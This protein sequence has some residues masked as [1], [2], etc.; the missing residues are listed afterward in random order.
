[1]SWMN[2]PY[3]GG[4][5]QQQLVQQQPTGFVQRTGFQPQVPYQQPQPTG[6]GPPMGMQPQPTGFAPPQM[7]QPMP[8]G[9]GGMAPPPQMPMNTGFGGGMA[10]PAPLR[11][12][13][14]GFNA[15]G[16]GAGV[17]SQFLST[18]MPAPGSAPIQPQRTGFNQ[19]PP[20]M[21]FQQQQ[22]GGPSLQQQFQ[23]SNQQQ[24]GHAQVA[25]PWA[26]TPEEKKR[27]DQIFRAWD[28]QG[29]G[30]LPGSMAKEVFGQAGLG[31]DDLMAI[32]N[33]ADV[34]DRG[35]LNID[36]FHVAMGLI[37]RRLNGNPIPNT[38]P[39]EMA[40]PS[41][42]DLEDSANFLTSLLKNDTNRR[43]TN[44][45]DFDSPQSRAKLRSLHDQSPAAS[46]KD[47][48][49]F[50]NDDN[51]V[52]AYKSSARHL[53]R[54]DVRSN[55]ASPSSE[56]DDVKRR[57]REAQR[58]V[59]RSREEDDEEEDL[60]EE[61]RRLNRKI[62]RVQDDLD[63]NRRSGRRTAAKDEERRLLERELLRLEHEDLPR[64]EKRLE[65]KEREKRLEQKKYAIERD[66]RNAASQRYAERSYRDDRDYG[67]SSSS[68]YADD[69]GYRS[70]SRRES[71]E[72]GYQ[73]GTY[74]AYDRSKYAPSPPRRS[75]PPRSRTPPPPPPAPEAAKVDAPP[76]PPP[77]APPS[78]AAAPDPKSM[79]PAERQAFIRAE[80]QRRIQDRLRAL[81]V[82]APSAAPVDT[83]VQDR[84]EAEKA[85]AARKAKEAD[86]L[87][88][89][90]ELERQAKLERERGR[91]QQI[92]AALQETQ[93][94]EQVVEQV[95]EEVERAAGLDGQGN[96]PAQAVKAAEEQLDAEEK[97][98]R[99]RE[100]R[101]R[102]EKEER[103]RRIEEM[104]REAK[105]AEEN[106]QRSKA[107]F[108]SGTAGAG[109]K[110]GPPPPP[111]SRGKPAPPPPKTRITPSP[112]PVAARPTAKAD[113]EDDWGTPAP[114]S[115]AASPPVPPPAPPIPVVS[116]PAALAPPQ[117]PSPPAVTSPAAKS[118]S[119]NPFHRLQGAASPAVSTASPTGGAPKPNPFFA[120]TP[121]AAPAAPPAPPAPPA[122]PPAPQQSKP[123]YRPP[124]SDD[125]DW[126]APGGLEKEVDES[127]SDDE[128]QIGS[129]RAKRAALA[130]NLFSGLGGGRPSSATPPTRS[131]AASPAPA[132]GAPPPPPPPGPPAAP[133]AL[134]VPLGAAAGEVN[135][136]GLLGQIQ[137]GLKLRKAKTM[138]RSGAVGAGAV[139]GDASAP[140]QHYSPPP[141]PPAQTPVSLPPVIHHSREDLADSAAALPAAP[142]APP[143]PPPPPAPPAPVFQAS[144]PEPE[145]APQEEYQPVEEHEP[146]PPAAESETLPA[147]ATE[148]PLENVDLS[149]TIRV[150]SIYTYDAQRDEDLGFV[151]NRVLIAH[152]AKDGGDW[153]YGSTEVDG[154]KL[155][156][157]P[158]AYVEEIHSQP[159]RA[160]FDY[161]AT[162]EDEH[163]FAEDETL[164]IVDSSD[165]SW[166]KA[167]KDGVVGLVPASYVELSTITA[168]KD[169]E[170]DS[171][172]SPMDVDASDDEPDSD[173]ES[174]AAARE[175]ERLRVLEAAGLL[176]R[177]PSPEA[178]AAPPKR[179]HRRPPPARPQRRPGSV[180]TVGTIEE[181]ERRRLEAQQREGEAEALREPEPEE[182]EERMEDAYD[183]YQRAMREQAAIDA[184][185]P[186]PIP[187]PALPPPSPPGSPS[188]STAPSTTSAVKDAWASTT[189]NLLSRVGGRSRSGTVGGE[190]SRPVISS[191]LV[192]NG[193]ENGDSTWASGVFG[194]SWSS[195]IDP[196]ALENLP[197]N[198]RKRQEA[199]YELIATEQSYVQSLQ[200]VIEVFL[201]A[202]QPTLPEKALKVIF[203]NIDEILLFDTIFLSELEERQRQSRL[204][205]NTIGDIVKEHM[206][207]VGSQY[208][209]FCVNQ[210]NAVRT[211]ADLK[212]SDRNLRT[213]LDSLR[214]KN[215]ELEHF[216]LEPMQRLTRY[217]LL[218]NQILRYTEP[219]HPDHA[220]LSRALQIAEGT[221]S[222]V[223]EAV[224]SHENEEKLAW[225]SDNIELPG[226]SSGHLNLMAP[227][228]LLGKRAILREGRVEKARSGRKLQVYLFN[229]LLIFTEAQPQGSGEIVYRYPIP[230][231]ESSVREHPRHDTDFIVTHRGETI[232]VRA[233]SP[234]V[235]QQWTRD[236]EQARRTC[237]AAVN[238]ARRG[239]KA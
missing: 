216:L 119:T 189:S 30:F 94:D 50:R 89:A 108:A 166:W 222:E 48:T 162:T 117:A 17:Q 178:G 65:Q 158:R 58:D 224:R 79:T 140:V 105:E 155:G 118:P 34:T 219:D 86:E 7:Q 88:K 220:T 203:A 211:L 133:K 112:A 175:A 42:R 170:P 184:R 195:L 90:K 36:E 15:Q 93:R 227:T 45:N 116:S 64:I 92:E 180:V 122:A 129:A 25:I 16:L 101:L 78:S 232:R 113:D 60:K 20:Q 146:E 87:Q 10:P 6:Y 8:T 47:A 85:E 135:R 183:L 190:K 102:R 52:P 206:K 169:D 114:R 70:S 177:D 239:S 53:N 41:A 111:V 67:R 154:G 231:E 229:D 4:Y 132:G 95:R 54:D 221:L 188:P 99:E 198:E 59:D 130:Q 38:L 199:C 51:A 2:R 164:A 152:P 11:P 150:R 19:P 126:D 144:E 91:G 125:D 209:G 134:S 43:A 185:N 120:S 181:E 223:N 80:A 145:P 172:Q 40:P 49:V 81:G 5:G 13:A 44:Q 171:P 22:Q 163:S 218:I 75:S 106:F 215:L 46:R 159:A 103:L 72:R 157:F 147:I 61:L 207:G 76:P 136:S 212:V 12:Q 131:A 156:F 32:W 69:D 115:A 33:L 110:K 77:A 83:S 71:P 28:Q 73:R 191:P 37:Y 179:R 9:F 234:R 84:L 128:P 14:T 149:Q 205:I 187:S 186:T 225:L 182:Q 137:G 237:L 27:Y 235:A 104:E 3:Q 236:I 139:I 174:S 208:R 192:G 217:P 160:L 151:E 196:S 127:D 121:P 39:P 226:M 153:W 176:V 230:L 165:E 201:N 210:S 100:E 35:K 96:E 123:A 63:D 107:A 143:P 68:R 204:Y 55:T 142:P 98:L 26:L 167:E 168:E 233:D 21:H 24:T 238:N 97:A 194:S 213:Q 57:L 193:S 82:A 200:L 148:D 18:F 138:D 62:Q 29:T 74:D 23:Q 124:P 109:A 141:S 202:L 1:M 56:L 173:D 31:Q 197:A 161:S 228:R 66:D 214:V